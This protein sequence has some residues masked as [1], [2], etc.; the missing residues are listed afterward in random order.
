MELLYQKPIIS[1]NDILEPLSISKPTANS[2]VGNF[3]K[4]GILKELTGYNRN[5]LFAFE[6]YLSI[7][8]QN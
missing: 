1:I 7:Y 4:L 5:K 2:L 6:K 8:S 3:E